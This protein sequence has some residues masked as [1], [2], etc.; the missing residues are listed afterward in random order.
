MT[1]L[2]GWIR[3]GCRMFQVKRITETQSQTFERHGV[4]DPNNQTL[5]VQHADNITKEA[6]ILFH[7]LFH[8]IH[9]MAGVYTGPD[10]MPL[11]KD[12]EDLAN[13]ESMA[14]LQ[15]MA[16]NPWLIGYLQEYVVAINATN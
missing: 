11:C 8:G 5:V 6:T 15:V 16:D 4:Y 12:E 1:Q 10:E 9:D 3:L 13:R 14:L 2:P 7:E